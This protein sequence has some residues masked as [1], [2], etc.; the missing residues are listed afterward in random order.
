[1]HSQ[2]TQ[3]DD[4]PSYVN[5]GVSEC[6]HFVAR[7]PA[8]CDAGSVA[9]DNHL[10]MQERCTGSSSEDLINIH[11]INHLMSRR[12]RV[13]NEDRVVRVSCAK[14]KKNVHF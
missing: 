13:R 11:Y 3:H 5:R 7:M 1:M 4:L 14:H 6:K 9:R 2:C 12:A 8:V 10:W